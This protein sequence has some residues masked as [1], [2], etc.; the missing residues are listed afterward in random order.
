MLQPGDF[1]FELAHGVSILGR[2]GA[3]A[4]IE[5]WVA[6][7]GYFRREQIREQN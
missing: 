3:R 4:D 2:S 5:L 6:D 1:R 7:L